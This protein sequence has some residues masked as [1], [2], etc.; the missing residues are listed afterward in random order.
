MLKL[1]DN[2]LGPDLLR[3]LRA[4]G[5]GD[6]IVVVDCNFPG[7]SVGPEIV[8]LEGILAPR[9]VDAILSLMPLDD[10][11][12][13]S[14]VRMEVVGNPSQ[15]EPIFR[16]F[17]AVVAKHEPKVTIKALERFAFYDRTKRAYAIVQSGEPALYGNLIL[18]KGIIHPAK[19]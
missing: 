6:E 2:I 17:D 12:D 4:M 10:F 9:I 13:D 7:D 8:R 1:I 15:I 11:V 3:I 14:A 5:H 19:V 18:K 16:A